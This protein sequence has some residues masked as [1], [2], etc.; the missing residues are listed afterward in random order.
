MN[1]TGKMLNFE[2]TVN[3]QAGTREYSESADNTKTGCFKRSCRANL[4]EWGGAK[5]W[6]CTCLGS[7]RRERRRGSDE[8]VQPNTSRCNSLLLAT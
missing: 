7:K 4:S 1:A 2:T 6:V 3:K 5:I 8:R